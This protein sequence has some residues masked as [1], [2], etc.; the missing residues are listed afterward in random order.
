MSDTRTATDETSSVEP[1][2]T[3]TRNRS[4]RLGIVGL[5]VLFVLLSA[6]LRLPTFGNHVFNSDEAYLATEAQVLDHGGRLYVDAVD[7]KPPIVPYIYAATF[8]VVG[9][10]DLTAV[11]VLAVLA[12]ALTALLL[13]FEARRRFRKGWSG[14]VVGLLYLLAATAFRPQDAQAAN[15]EVFMLPAMTAAMVLGIRRRSGAAGAA[16]AVATLAK[17]TAATTL[18]PLAWLGGGRDGREVWPC[19]RA[20]LSSPSSLSLR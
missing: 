19:S 9:N 1:H 18:L 12:H 13:A 10:D 17:Q 2:D 5:V 16:L 20:R 3:H 7:R 4:R 8:S 6:A 15:F 11:R 14:V